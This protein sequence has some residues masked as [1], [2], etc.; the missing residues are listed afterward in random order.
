MN[1]T[2]PIGTPLTFVWRF[3]KPNNEPYCFVPDTHAFRLRYYTGR[4]SK[5]V[6]SFMLNA[7]H[8][9]ITWTIP[10]EEKLPAGSYSLV[11]DV[12]A[13]GLAVGHFHYKDAFI[14]YKSH[15]VDIPDAEQT[16]AGGT[17]TLLS[18]AEFQHFA[19]GESAYQ[20][21]VQ[22]GYE[23]TEEEWLND[24]V[25]GIKGNGIKSVE[26]VGEYSSDDSA[27]NTYRITPY[28]GDPFDFKV[29]NG[30]GIA[31]VQ[32]TTTSTESEG[33]NEITVTF[34]DGTAA[35]FQVK[36]GAR[37]NSGYSGA[38]EDLEVVND[39]DADDPEADAAKALS[40]YQGYV[41]GGKVTELG[42]ELDFIP[43]AEHAGYLRSDGTYTN[44]ATYHSLTTDRIKCVPGD[45]FMYRGVGRAGAISALYYTNN[46]IT[47]SSQVDSSTKFSEIVIPDGIDEVRFSSFS[48]LD[49]DI[50]LNVYHASQVI[51]SINGNISEMTSGLYG[52]ILSNTEVSKTEVSFIPVNINKGDYFQVKIDVDITRIT[53]FII[54]YNGN[55][56]NRLF[57]TTDMSKVGVWLDFYAPENLTY[58]GYWLDVSSSVTLSVRVGGAITELR[59][60]I[61][62][63]D[64]QVLHG[65]IGVSFGDSI[66]RGNGNNNHGPLDLLISDYQCDGT[67]YAIG[68][69]TCAENSERS[70]IVAQIQDAIAAQISPDFIL[71]DGGSNDMLYS[72][73]G[74]L[75]DSFDY[76]AKGYATYTDGLEYCFGLL[77]D[78]FPDVPIL[79]VLPHSTPSRIYAT[80]QQFWDRARDICKKWS[81]PVADVERD[82]NLN[83]RIAV[84]LTAFADEGGTHPNGAGYQYAYIPLI[85]AKLKRIF[86]YRINT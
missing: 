4:G 62:S 9:A 77:K 32:Q 29:K 71:L 46:V 53:R 22:H 47:S 57:E 11:L 25:N 14:L 64:T 60:A 36:N 26:I 5:D 39:L 51:S 6:S 16:A 2:Y 31:S 35:T 63:S 37:G 65:K 82:G 68:G 45:K 54:N 48:P 83:T 72:Q 67:N 28:V 3:L 34:S 56:N 86:G 74:T 61:L 44:G 12:F 58:I 7:T 73:L 18:V 59:G 30:K 80:E 81:I 21:A 66:M 38:A 17:I 10:A 78:T 70:H 49:D 84:Q 13:E 50:I 33:V 76:V 42:Q 19:A 40:A 55:N 52:T 75:T 69:A 23:G 79:F 8:D 85:V 27:E 41:L 1:N 15:G 43:S 20:I 24:P